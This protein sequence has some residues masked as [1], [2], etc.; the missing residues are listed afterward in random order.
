MYIHMY[1]CTLLRLSGQFLTVFFIHTSKSSLHV[2]NFFFSYPCFLYGLPVYCLVGL[3]E[4]C[5]ICFLLSLLVLFPC[6]YRSFGRFFIFFS[7]LSLESFFSSSRRYLGNFFVSSLCL[8]ISFPLS[9]GSFRRFLV[10]VHWDFSNIPFYS[11]GGLLGD[12][13]LFCCYLSCISFRS[14]PNLKT[15]CLFYCNISSVPFFLSILF[16]LSG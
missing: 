6:S 3:L 2:V 11:L 14:R 16:I 5:Y 7:L 13:S 9:C 10:F 8:W 15:F 1:N 4:K 12:L